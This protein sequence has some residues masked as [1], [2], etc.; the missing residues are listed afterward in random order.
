MSALV[1][2]LVVGLAVGA[3]VIFCCVKNIFKEKKVRERERK[4]NTHKLC[5]DTC[6]CV[7]F[8]QEERR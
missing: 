6:R 8:P 2:G 7:F 4:H 5:I 1:V 3:V